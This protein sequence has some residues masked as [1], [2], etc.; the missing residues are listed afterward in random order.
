M[1]RTRAEGSAS[2]SH[3]D[4]WRKSSA[5]W[6]NSKCKCPGVEMHSLCSKISTGDKVAG[7]EY[8]KQKVVRYEVTLIMR[9]QIIW[10]LVDSWFLSGV[11]WKN[12]WRVLHKGVK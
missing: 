1:F 10:G 3:A 2:V 4:N 6:G 5:G 12:H 9:G 8:M 7:A 11:M